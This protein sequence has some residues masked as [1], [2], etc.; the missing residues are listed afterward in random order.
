MTSRFALRAVA[1]G[2]VADAVTAAVDRLL[3]RFVSDDVR[4][5]ELAVRAGSPHRIAG[6]R[7]VE[8]V[9]GRP[10]GEPGTRA[11]RL[12]FT[13]AYGVAWGLVYAAVR[14]RYPAAAR[15]AGV[16]FAVPFYLACDGLIAPALGLTPT[17][18]GVPWQLNA[19]EL[20]N[21]VAW[22]ATAEAVHRAAA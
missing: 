5:R 22:T 16:P 15:L 14:R 11:A 7:A 4:R 8:K 6:P 19:K 1:A 10:L 13:V 21:H 9:A 20:A 12:G 17:P 3:D 18:P 2:L